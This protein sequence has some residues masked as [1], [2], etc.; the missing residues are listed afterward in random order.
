MPVIIPT[1]DPTRGGTTT[2]PP[3]GSGGGHNSGGGGNHGGGGKGRGRNSV[4][5]ELE[6]QENTSVEE[7]EEAKEEITE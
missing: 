1:L 5:P 3:K 2:N 7:T 4:T 6:V